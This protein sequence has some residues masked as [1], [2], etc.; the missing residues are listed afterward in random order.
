MTINIPNILLNSIL[1]RDGNL[2]NVCH[3]NAG[4]I[5]K[6]IDD[7]RQIFEN[8]NVHLIAISETWL[9]S[10]HSKN[11]VKL[12]G[13]DVFR[14]DRQ[15]IQSGGVAVYVK[16][17]LKVKVVR[18]ADGI[19]SEYL[20][21]EI[22]FPNSKILFGAYYKAPKVDEIYEFDEVLYKLATNYDDIIITGDLNENLLCRDAIGNCSRCKSRCCSSCRFRTCLDKYG[23]TSLGTE[24]TNFDQTP[25]LIDLFL[26]NKPRKV[27]VFNQISTGLSN[28]DLILASYSTV[29]PIMDEKP[30]LWRNF[31]A[32]DRAKLSRDLEEADLAKVYE[33]TDVD[34]MIEAFNA[35][36]VGLMDKHA[37]LKPFI[38]R[39]GINCSQLWYTREMS[40]AAANRDLARR[41]YRSSKTPENLREYR[42]LRNVANQL[43]EDGKRNYLRK[44]LNRDIGMKKVWRNAKE[45]GLVASRTHSVAP[46]FTAGEFNEYTTRRTYDRQTDT[47]EK[48]PADPMPSDLHLKSGSNDAVFA[49]RNVSEL[50]VYEAVSAVKS[51]AMGLD[52]IPMKFIEIILLD[53]LPFVT[54]IVNTSIMSS[55][56]IGEWK[57]AK[58]LPTHKRSKTYDLNDYRPISI[59]PVFSKVFEILLKRQIMEHLRQHKLISSHQSGFRTSHSTTTALLKVSDDIKR[60]MSGRMTAIMLLLDF[61]KAFDSVTHGLLCSKL[62]TQFYFDSTA[63]AMI[64]DYLNGRLQAVSIDGVLSTYLPVTRGIPQGSILGPVLFLLFINDMP[65]SIRHMLTHLF[66]DDVQM[67][68][69]FDMSG[70]LSSV[71]EINVDMRAVSSW[72]KS[73]KLEL[74]AKKSQGIVISTKD[75]DYSPLIRLD[76]TSI[77]FYSKVKNLGLIINNKFQ[78]MDQAEAIHSKVF[79]GLRSLWP[80]SKFT[81]M[82]TR[83]MLARSL[84]MPH[85]EYCSI[86]FTYGLDHNAKRLLNSAFNATVRYVYGLKRSDSVESHAVRFVGF[87]LEGYFKYRAMLFIYKLIS[88]KSPKYLSDLIEIDFESR[89]KQAKIQR[90]S[91]MLGGTIYGKGLVDW[92]RLPV[93]VRCSQSHELFGKR[94]AEYAR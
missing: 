48:L 92:N 1:K 93:A 51:K 35:L 67:Y 9:K 10:Y 16:K 84:L 6:K 46:A 59:L 57:K 79:A 39:P 41:A 17:G 5:F 77:P 91:A 45:M 61:T 60:T 47:S 25:S 3:I 24:P 76:G 2:L 21:M 37:P 32:I 15:K 54:H 78:W 7:L 88:C 34:C 58:V 68:K 12:E 85:F 49:F 63:V 66:A 36:I 22:I 75:V 94:Y 23:L 44:R 80:F 86:V 62:R 64:L 4:S 55:K 40:I 19:K 11:S 52:G 56:C 18:T 29:D 38:Q 69:V 20:F 33:L 8:T 89:T 82:K 43:V 53:V 81:P 74:N 31:K 83:E 73:N 27:A 71:E 70:L 28:H 26:T 42:R 30:K 65:G 14:N 72:A 87:P 50:E 13:F 90:C